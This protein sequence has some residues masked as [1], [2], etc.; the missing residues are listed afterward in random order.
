MNKKNIIVIILII[1]ILICAAFFIS[2]TNNN[3]NNLSDES[4]AINLY[5]NLIDKYLQDTIILQS[6]YN[7]ILIDTEKFEDPL[8]NNALS[9]ASK[10]E[11]LNHCKKYNIDFYDKQKN[12]SLDGVTITFDI[13]KKNIIDVIVKNYFNKSISGRNYICE[14][15]SGVWHIKN[16]NIAWSS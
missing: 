16:G 11:V 5:K 14:Y 3:N 8:N 2:F 15:N 12:E 4:A 10:S 13:S 7:C 6:N 9:N 1:I